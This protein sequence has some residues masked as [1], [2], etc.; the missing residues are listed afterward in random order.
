MIVVAAAGGGIAASAWTAQVLTGLEESFGKEFRDSLFIVSSVSGGSV[1][2]MY[3]LT[4]FDRSARHSCRLEAIRAAAAASSLEQ[5]AWGFAGPDFWKFFIASAPGT[6]G[7]GVALEAAWKKQ[8]IIH[9]LS[10]RPFDGEMYAGERLLDVARRVCQGKAPIALYN[11]TVVETGEPFVF[12]PIQIY[13]RSGQ[14]FLGFR[15]FLDEYPGFDVEIATAAR[16][17]ATFPFVS[18]VARPRAFADGSLTSGDVRPAW[19]LADGGYYDN[20]GAFT[21]LR[22]LNQLVPEF[23]RNGGRKILFI[24]IALTDSRAIADGSQLN[25]SIYKSIQDWIQNVLSP[26]FTLANVRTTSQPYRNQFDTNLFRQRWKK[27]NGSQSTTPQIKFEHVI[28]ALHD[29]QAPNSWHLTRKQKDRIR[30]AWERTLRQAMV[31]KPH[32]GL[33]RI[34]KMLDVTSTKLSDACRV[35]LNGLRMSMPR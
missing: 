15:N 30:N 9:K 27:A 26:L 8:F 12:A 14:G 13:D 4:G 5:V 1:G 11:A 3:Y 2:S 23:C 33:N 35:Q 18:P 20:F 31:G 28:F 21:L 22:L 19:H 6:Y 24:Q 25:E 32:S 10:P 7:R 34:R 17:S 16:M 29:D